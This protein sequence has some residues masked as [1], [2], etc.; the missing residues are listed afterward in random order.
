MEFVSLLQCH[1]KGVAEL[2]D[3]AFFLWAAEDIC[4]VSI[5]DICGR[6]PYAYVFTVLQARSM[7]ALLKSVDSFVTCVDDLSE[8]W[9]LCRHEMNGIVSFSA[10]SLLDAEG[11][12]YDSPKCLFSVDSF[13]FPG[14]SDTPPT[15]CLF[16]RSPSMVPVVDGE[17]VKTEAARVRVTLS[18]R[19]E[20]VQP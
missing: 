14:G 4:G 19:H 17:K 2:C 10:F 18:A 6:L 7:K 12:K 13:S 11:E 9:A 20:L 16:W 5:E 8:L 15:I 1:G 3:N